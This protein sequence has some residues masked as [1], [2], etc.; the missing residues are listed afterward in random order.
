MLDEMSREALRNLEFKTPR[1]NEEVIQRF[2]RLEDKR[3]LCCIDL[4]MT[5]W[6]T[7][8]DGTA[9]PRQ[10]EIIDIGIVVLEVSGLRESLRL[11]TLARPA[12]G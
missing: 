4:E 3:Y 6:D 7:L 10:Q 1:H 5:C 12:A 9:D 2:G 8:P 11:E